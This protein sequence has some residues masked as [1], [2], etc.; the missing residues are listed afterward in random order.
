MAP[1]ERPAKAEQRQAVDNRERV[2]Q[3]ALGKSPAREERW[4]AVAPHNRERVE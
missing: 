3:M 4:E 2:E 1:A